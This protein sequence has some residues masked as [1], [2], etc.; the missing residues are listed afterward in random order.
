MK[1]CLRHP[2]VWK[3]QGAARSVGTPSENVPRG[4]RRARRL[5]T[6]FTSGEPNENCAVMGHAAPGPNDSSPTESRCLHLPAIPPPI[7]GPRV[8]QPDPIRF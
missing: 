1:V 4:S 2:L 7:S 8:G 3:T 6:L 5:N